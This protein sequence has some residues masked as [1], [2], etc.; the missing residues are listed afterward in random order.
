MKHAFDKSIAKVREELQNIDA[1]CPHIHH[2]RPRGMDESLACTEVTKAGHPLPCASG[3]CGSKLRILRATF[4]HYPAMRKLLYTVYMARAHHGNVANIDNALCTYDYKTLCKLLSV[5]ECE[6]LVTQS[7]K[8][9]EAEKPLEYFAEGLINVESQILMKYANVFEQYKGK[10]EK[11][12]E[13]PCS[14]CERLHKRSYITKYTADTQKFNSD[15][16]VQLK[17]FLANRDDDFDDKNY[18]ICQHCRPLLNNN[19]IPSTCMLNGLYVE[20]IPKE[21]SQ[22]NALGRQLVQCVKPFQTI[23]RLGTYTEKVP[24]YNATK[25]IKGTMF[26]LPLPLQNTIEAFDDLGINN[27]TSDDLQ[28]L[29]DPELYIL[30][31]GRPTKDK[32]VWQTLVDVNDI[33][34][35]V[36]KLKETNWLYKNIDENSVDDAA[37]KAIEVVS[38]TSST[39]I[40]KATK[41]DIAELEAYTIR[42]MDE[43]LP[44]GSDLEHYKML[45]IEEPALDNRLKYLDVMCFPYLFPSGRYGEFH[46]R[47]PFVSISSHVY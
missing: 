2:I 3:M 16:W 22:L 30:L 10:L 34:K 20:E 36:N 24:I 25:G 45:K 47:E 40:K 11:D 42:R 4:V 39:L 8:S 7:S 35:A 15:K 29:P 14:S 18:Y 32:V 5:E 41:A 19:K 26:F 46:P 33:K 28:M 6:E 38:S 1:G 43:S 37:K 21:L 9:E 44:L 13:Y 31:D 17:Q 27:L 23:I 12:F